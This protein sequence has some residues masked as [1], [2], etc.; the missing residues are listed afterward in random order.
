MRQGITKCV[1]ALRAVFPAGF[2]VRSQL[3]LA[4]GAES[5]PEP[6]VAVVLGK[7]DDYRKAHPTAALLVLEVSDA[8]ELH[9][10][11][12]K[13]LLYARG[14]IPEYWM[15]NLVRDCVEVHRDP[16]DGAYST[17]LVLGRGERIA[18]LARPDAP[19]AV[20]DLLPLR[21]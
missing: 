17:R 9:D 4:L 13:A 14:G 3:P 19:I 11:N 8:S 15:A 18:P 12:R 6:D 5:M 20:E 7:P 16:I 1:D 2:L 10:R 21:D